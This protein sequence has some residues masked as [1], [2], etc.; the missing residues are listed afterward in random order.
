MQVYF[1]DT[2]LTKKHH[3]WVR[4]QVDFYDF[5]FEQALNACTTCI[6]EELAAEFHDGSIPYERTIRAI[7]QKFPSF[8]DAWAAYRQEDSE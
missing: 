5:I 6:K 8:E 4:V 2:N 1:D 3:S 7:E